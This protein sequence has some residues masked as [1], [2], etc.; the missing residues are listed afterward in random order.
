MI[1]FSLNMS[2]LTFTERL[3]RL[4]SVDYL[5]KALKSLEALPESHPTGCGRN[6]LTFLD[7]VLLE[8]CN[9]AISGDCKSAQQNV[10]TFAYD[11]LNTQAASAQDHPE[12]VDLSQVRKNISNKTS[13]ICIGF[14]LKL[15][16]NVAES[17]RMLWSLF[18]MI[19]CR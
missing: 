6:Q 7:T 14:F 15:A 11:R 2:I 8:N 4:T 16:L 12:I 9:L 19:A 3:R 13:F 5:N 1:C 10:A 18:E 17:T